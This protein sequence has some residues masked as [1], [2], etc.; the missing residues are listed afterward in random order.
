MIIT[1][2]LVLVLVLVD[3]IGLRKVGEA[4]DSLIEA[5]GEKSESDNKLIMALH[6]Q[7][8][9]QQMIIEGHEK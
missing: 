4:R 7:L 6:D 3:L 1:L 2:A 9:S 8:L 5:Y